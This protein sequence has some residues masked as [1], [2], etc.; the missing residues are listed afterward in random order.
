MTRLPTTFYRYRDFSTNTLDLRRR[1]K[2]EVLR[3]L[4]QAR[5]KGDAATAHAEKKALS[6]AQRELANIACNATDPEYTASESEA[7]SWLL[8]R[9]IERELR[10]HYE[11]GVC[12]FSTT[13]ASPLLWSHYGDQHR[14]LCIGYG[15]DRRPKPYLRRVMYGGSRSVQTS[16]LTRALVR[17]DSKAKEELDRCVL[18]RKARGWRRF[19][20]T[21]CRK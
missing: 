14:G 16:V 20:T 15:V 7:E 6:E 1:V 17:E 3:L 9:Q 11:Q 2:S 19:A 18:L 8:A 21:K 10:R 13:Y 5:I 4:T 12:C